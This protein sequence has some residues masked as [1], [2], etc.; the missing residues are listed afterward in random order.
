MFVDYVSCSTSHS[1]ES[2]SAD[3]ISIIPICAGPGKISCVKLFTISNVMDS[4]HVRKSSE[5]LAV[6]SSSYNYRSYVRP[7]KDKFPQ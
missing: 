6:P 5:F 7:F 3:M 2:H 4:E 1:V